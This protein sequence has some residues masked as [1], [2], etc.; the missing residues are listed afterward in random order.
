MCVVFRREDKIRLDQEKR[1]QDALQKRLA[2]QRKKEEE[3]ELLRVAEQERLLEEQVAEKQRE[4][5]TMRAMEKK[6]QEEME[7][8]AKSSPRGTPK[9]VSALE[10][11]VGPPA[12]IANTFGVQL[13]TQSA[14]KTDT[15]PVHSIGPK[16]VVLQYEDN[17][18]NDIEVTSFIV[19]LHTV[20]TRVYLSNISL[21][22][23][24]NRLQ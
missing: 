7:Y 5:D 23:I 14:A 16:P 17:I 21:I 13:K 6:V 24:I 12:S 19:C 22:T 4:L 10:E 8:K 2:Q 11:D 3:D 18:Q 15:S 9:K 20:Y 1:D